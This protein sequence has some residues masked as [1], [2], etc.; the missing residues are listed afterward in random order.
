LRIA[1]GPPESFRALP[2][3]F[4]QLFAAVGTILDLVRVGV[5]DQPQLERIDM[6]RISELIHR[7]FDRIKPFSSARRAH[8]ARR[9]LVELHKPLP[10]FGVRAAI[11]LARPADEM[12]LEI[13]ELRPH[14]DGVVTK[15]DELAIALGPERQLLDDAGPVSE[16]EHLLARERHPHRSLERAR[17]KH[18][19]G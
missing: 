4:A 18:R 15:R 14:R 2:V 5:V 11:E 16:G 1:S 10:A 7:A 8:V 12:T 17:R 6:S 9:V 13:F 19:E 3:A